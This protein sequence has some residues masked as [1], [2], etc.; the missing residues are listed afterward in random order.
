MKELVGGC[1]LKVGTDEALDKSPLLLP[2]AGAAAD[3][4]GLS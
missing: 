4:D 3:T 1:G 2:W